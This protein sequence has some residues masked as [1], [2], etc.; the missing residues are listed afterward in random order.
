[1]ALQCVFCLLFRLLPKATRTDTLFP[2]TTLVRSVAAS[3]HVQLHRG[4][5]TV[6]HR[7]ARV[8]RRY[9]LHGPHAAAEADALDAEQVTGLDGH[10]PQPEDRKSPRLTSSH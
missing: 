6:A 7:V 2:Y 4:I 9:H 8:L 3:F 10:G 1:M 5:D